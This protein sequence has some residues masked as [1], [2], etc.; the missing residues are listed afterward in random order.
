MKE[1]KLK[2]Q[3]TSAVNKSTVENTSKTIDIIEKAKEY[4]TKFYNIENISEKE[5]MERIKP[6]LSE[7]AYKSLLPNSKE[8]NDNSNTNFKTYVSDLKL[9]I[10]D[11]SVTTTKVL[12][13]FNLHTTVQ[14]RN[15]TTSK[16]LVELEINNESKVIDKQPIV[17]VLS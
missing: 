4:I 6:Y 10:N 1:Q 7:T 5:R 11:E 8:L 3:K 16:Y 2:E 13:R 12:A 17:T 9:Y 14:Q 15:T